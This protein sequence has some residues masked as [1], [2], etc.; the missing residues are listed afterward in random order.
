MPNQ[1]AGAELGRHLASVAGQH[2]LQITA[3]DRGR[4]SGTLEAIKARWFLGGRKVVYRMSCDLDEPSHRVRFRE[5]ALESSWGIPPP[6][7]S[8]ETTTQHGTKVSE[9]RVDTS[10]GGGGHLDYGSLRTAFEQTVRDDGWT[11]TLETGKSP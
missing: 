4:L 9:S 1:V 6:T 11:F 2:G 8:V 7:F 5:A 3:T 10:V